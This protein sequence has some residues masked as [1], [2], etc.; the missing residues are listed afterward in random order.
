MD[1]LKMLPFLFAA[2]LL[3]EALENVS[4]K[5]SAFLLEKVGKAG[6][7]VG[8]VLGCIPQCGFSVMASNFYAG[9]MI[10]V[11][12][13]L[14]VFLATSDEAVLLMITQ[15]QSSGEILKLLAVKVA[16]AIVAGYLV[17]IFLGKKIT[18]KKEMDEICHDCGCHDSHGILIPAIRHTVKIFIYILVFTM[19][20][21]A[22][23]EIVGIEQLSAYLLGDTIFQPVAAAVIGLIPNCVASVMLTQ[24]YIAGAITFPSVV[25]GLCSSAGIAMVVLFKM[26]HH[27]KENMKIFG[28]LLAIAVIAGMVLQIFM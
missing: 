15:P 26:N 4:E 24:L 17:D 1:S 2:F 21:S 27:R 14:A 13:L 10:T 23:I 11:G 6:P 8:A 16:I 25:A 9:G 20:L 19:I 3:L 5:V 28:A 18:E 12:T 22:V 7:I